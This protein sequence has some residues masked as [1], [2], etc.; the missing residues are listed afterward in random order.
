[1]PKQ[2]AELTT[3]TRPDSLWVGQNMKENNQ[4]YVIIVVRN[5]EEV[6]HLKAK[7]LQGP[8]GP[9]AHFS[10][11]TFGEYRVIATLMGQTSIYHDTY[12]TGVPDRV[13]DEKKKIVSKYLPELRDKYARLCA[14]HSFVEVNLTEIARTVS[15]GRKVE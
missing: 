3:A 15:L 4:E 5:P 14:Q 2:H 1:M 9:D 11:G 6:R 8:V 13:V 7:A 10:Y 12:E